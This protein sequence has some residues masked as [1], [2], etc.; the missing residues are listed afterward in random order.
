MEYLGH[1]INGGNVAVPE[2][3]VTAKAEYAK[4]KTK[5]Q[6]RSFLGSVGYYYCFIERFARMSASLIPATAF[7]APHR[8][9]RTEEMTRCFSKLCISLCSRVMLYVRDVS[10]DVLYTAISGVGIGACLHVCQEDV[11]VA[12]LEVLKFAIRSQSWKVR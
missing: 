7:S 12:T 3:T 1:H 2:H 4:P 5:R 9:E 6:L 10:D 8:V 11:D